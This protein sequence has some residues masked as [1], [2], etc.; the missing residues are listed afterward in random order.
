MND[1]QRRHECE[2]RHVLGMTSRAVRKAY[3]LQ[4]EAKRGAEAARQLR[5]AVEKAWSSREVKP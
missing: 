4:V 5:E 2:V 3:L 1:E